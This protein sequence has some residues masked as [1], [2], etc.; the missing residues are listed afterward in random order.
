MLTSTIKFITNIFQKRDSPK[1]VEEYKV[2]IDVILGKLELILSDGNHFAQSNVITNLRNYLEENNY[3]AFLNEL[4]SVNMW[5]GAGAVWEVYFNDGNLEKRFAQKMI[6]L[7]DLMK[8][9]GIDS[10][11]SN[12]VRKLF[13]SQ[14]NN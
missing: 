13:F 10:Y 14:L 5:G 11:G 9:L 12:S 4:H 2:A 7:I 8:Q 3:V 1:M 6:K